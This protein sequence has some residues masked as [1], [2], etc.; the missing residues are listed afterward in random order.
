MVVAAVVMVVRVV[1]RPNTTRARLPLLS[2]PPLLLLLLLL[3]AAAGVGRDSA[4]R[5][6]ST[7]AL[8]TALDP[9]AVASPLATRAPSLATAAAAAAVAAAPAAALTPNATRRLLF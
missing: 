8:T 3:G 7:P 4:R 1:L 2:L 9:T 5:A 6:V